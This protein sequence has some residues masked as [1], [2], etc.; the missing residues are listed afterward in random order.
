MASTIMQFPRQDL[1]QKDKNERWFKDHLDYAENLV[2]NYNTTKQRM[3]RF[4]EGYNGIKQPGSIDWLTKTYGLENRAKFISYRL[5]RTKID[6]LHG[7]W[8]KRPMAVTVSTINS[9]AI[10]EKVRQQNFVAGAMMMRK[11]I[12][13]VKNIAGVDPTEG[14]YIPKD[15]SEFQKMSFKDKCEDIAQIICDNQVIQLDVKK[16][17]GDGFKNCEIT[18]HVFGQIE[19]DENGMIQ[20]HNIDPRRAIYVATEGDDYLEKS[21]IMGCVKT[22][23]VH[24][25]LMQYELTKEQRDQLDTARKNYNAYVGLEGFSRGYMSYNNGELLCDVI[26]ITWKSVKPIYI[27]VVPKTASQLMLDNST[28]ELEF[29]MD[30]EKYESNKAIHDANVEKG[31]YKVVTKFMSYECEATRIGGIIDI[32]MRETY[33]QKRSVDKPSHVLNSTY[34]GYIHGRVDGVTVPI[35]Q[36]IENFDNLYD[37]VKYQQTREIAKSKGKVLTID[38]AGLGVNQTLK[39]TYYRMAN[40]QVLEYDSSAAGNLG[41]RNLDPSVMFQEHDMGL[42]QSFQSLL[43]VEQSII[44]SLNQITGINENRQGQTAASS[45]ATAQQSDIANSR[46]ITEALFYGYSGYVKRVMKGI[47]DASAL[48]YAFFQQGRGEQLLGTERFAFLQNNIE[49]AYRD[50]GVSIEDGTKHLEIAEKLDVLMNVALNAKEI[51]VMDAMNVMLAETLAQ[52]KA[53]L[54]SALQRSMLIAQQQLQEEQQ[55]QAQMQQ[56]QLQTQVQMAQENREDEQASKID[57]INAK[58]QGQIM[59]DNNKA[60]LDKGLMFMQ[61]QSDIIRDTEL[62]KQ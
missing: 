3:T 18:N 28:T 51:H 24:Q 57:Q 29:E 19:R 9:D 4:F 58:T 15:E 33:L 35:Q 36:M 30:T 11:E 31:L 56:Q 44:A 1:P 54:E 60:E 47:V 41:N 49:L 23:P 12:E 61:T 16:K 59:I 37:I 27:K 50:Y 32:N 34:V 42:S 14:M 6:L 48:S 2:R 46:T 21:P 43:M 22:M 13:D 55:A 5:G 53:F 52:K 10:N 45:T 38:K 39:D 8:L 25:I 7:E 20:F 26:H 17:L 62:P 40:D